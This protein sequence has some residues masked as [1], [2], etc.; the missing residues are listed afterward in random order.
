MDWSKVNHF[1][2]N[3]YMMLIYN[4]VYSWIFIPFIFLSYRWKKKQKSSEKNI[5]V[6]IFHFSRHVHKILSAYTILHTCNSPDDYFWTLFS[7]SF[8]APFAFLNKVFSDFL[9]VNRIW[10]GLF[11]LRVIRLHVE[12]YYS[13]YGIDAVFENM[14][15]HWLSY[16]WRIT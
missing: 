4:V 10:L 16:G 9:L 1:D 8:N 5:N 13:F 14:K 7:S 11:A 3:V 2:F 15:S 12:N 6:S